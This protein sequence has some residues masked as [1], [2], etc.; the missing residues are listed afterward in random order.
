MSSHLKGKDTL[1]LPFNKGRDGAAGN[2]PNPNGYATAYLW[3][4]ILRKD[5]WLKII[6]RYVHLEVKEKEDFTGKKYKSESL[7]FPRYHQLDVVTSLL[8]DAK[9]NGAGQK[10][11][12]QHS[13][14]S[15]KSNS[16]AWLAHQLS[17]LQTDTNERVFN[18][19]I[20]VTDRTVLD[21][22]LQETIS[23][24]EHKDGV[25]VRINREDGDG[26]KSAQLTGALEKAPQ[27]S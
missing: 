13:A 3:E 19:V 26:S 12:I 18:S 24:F 2:P 25:V 10:Y 22:Q 23:Q 6:G 4:E 7:I 11:L 9:T 8:S 17:S 1:F 5:T 15:G 20:V 27:S 16:I 14:G 21:N